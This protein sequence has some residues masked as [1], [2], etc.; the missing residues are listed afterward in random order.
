MA[1]VV[2]VV[3]RSSF[4]AL[5]VQH[6]MPVSRVPCQRKLFR[7]VMGASE[8]AVD[9]GGSNSPAADDNEEDASSSP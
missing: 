3:P 8:E 4:I 2:G 1:S 6:Y 9:G 7:A 5:D